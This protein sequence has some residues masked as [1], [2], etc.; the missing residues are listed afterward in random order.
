VVLAAFLE[1]AATEKK[2][3]ASETSGN[4]TQTCSILACHSTN[5][6]EEYD[7]CAFSGIILLTALTPNDLAKG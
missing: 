5:K 3:R 4:W 7:S 2:F 6:L 1:T